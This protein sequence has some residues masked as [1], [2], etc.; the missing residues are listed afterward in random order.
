MGREVIVPKGV[1]CPVD[2]DALFL[3]K[4]RIVTVITAGSD[5]EGTITLCVGIASFGRTC[6]QPAVD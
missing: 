3:Q 4:P 6:A 5:S 1:A 2:A